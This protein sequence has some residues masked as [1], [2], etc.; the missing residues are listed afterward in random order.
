MERKNV[1]LKIVGDGPA[2]DSL[3]NLATSLNLKD[4]VK[5]LGCVFGKELVKI[6]Q[7][8]DIFIKYV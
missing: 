2:L 7:K 3:R 5:F 4:K 6:Y 1:S 8:N